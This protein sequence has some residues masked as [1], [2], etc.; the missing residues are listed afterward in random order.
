MLWARMC[1]RGGAALSLWLACPAGGYLP[2]GL[3]NGQACAHRCIVDVLNVS[4]NSALEL[5]KAL[6]RLC[7]RLQRAFKAC[8][9]VNFVFSVRFFEN[10]L[11]DYKFRNIWM[12][13]QSARWFGAKST[14]HVCISGI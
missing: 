14:L 4:E 9:R 12:T 2:R 6:P 13:V 11:L 8:C 1:G 3:Q 5:R 7:C 10:M